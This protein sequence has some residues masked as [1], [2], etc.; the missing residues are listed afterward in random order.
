[1]GTAARF[2]L[3]FGVGTDGAGNLYVA[4]TRSVRGI[5]LATREATT[6]AGVAQP[7]GS[8][9]VA[10]GVG[11]AAKFA[12]AW[13]ITTDS[14]GNLYVTDQSHT[15]RKI[16]P[17]GAVTT[18]AGLAGSYG[19][20]DGSLSAAR[21]NGPM[22]S[23]IAGTAGLYG[24]TDAI[25]T[26]ARFT[27]P[28]GLAVDN[29]RNLLY[30]ADSLNRTIRSIDLATRSVSTIAGTAGVPGSGDG[31]GTAARFLLPSDVVGER[32]RNRERGPLLVAARDRGRPF[33]KPPRDGP[34]RG[35][36]LDPDRPAG[37]RRRGDD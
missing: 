10:D 22:V 17:S 4:D 35:E 28:F 34:G 27:Q 25:G 11:S 5:V 32:G 24:S 13:G 7:P 15:I 8:G 31:T 36:P 14:A 16:T 1:V 30:V 2:L 6:L 29:G 26:A 9:G 18:F 20:A 12:A 23:T 3:P 33:G 21:F 37:S 19:S